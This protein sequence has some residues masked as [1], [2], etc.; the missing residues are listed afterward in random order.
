MSDR[1]TDRPLPSGGR[2]LRWSVRLLA[3]LLRGF[4][5]RRV[6]VVGARRQPSPP[7]GCRLIVSSHRNGAIDGYVVL[8]AFP[9][10]QGLVSI[11]LLQHPLLRWMFDGIA[12]VREKDRQR[13]GVRRAT[14]ANPVDAGCA[15]L[16]AGGD[17]LVF[18]EGSSEW[19]HR[20]LPYQR[21]A[22]RI[23]RTMLAEGA[24]LELVPLGLYYQAPDRFRSDVEVLA[25][26]PLA[27]PARRAE[28]ADRAWELRIHQAIAEALDAVS[29]RCTDAAGF[30][31]AEAQAQ[32]AAAQGESY[33]L[34]F[35][36]AQCKRHSGRTPP[37]PPPTCPGRAW[38]WDWLGVAAFMLLAA[39]VLL[40]GRVAGGKADARNTVSFFRMAGG[41]VAALPWLPCLVL[42]TYGQ[43]GPMLILGL[44][45]AWGWWRW[46]RVMHRGAR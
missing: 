23:A 15:Q 21:G 4:Y 5:F 14:F 29:V 30:A 32:A 31:S 40:I 35:V 26:P 3:W 19:G 10:V 36:D 33:A 16:R 8:R 37:V 18:P 46:P 1:S 42:A 2:P 13:H 7:R 6:S 17:L 27:L 12:V 20:P 39:P 9:G 24:P 22:A 28:E 41:L 34:A 45:A 25:G 11:Q 44:F 38:P 43:P